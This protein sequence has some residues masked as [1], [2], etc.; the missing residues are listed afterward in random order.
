[1]TEPIPYQTGER[2]E[3]SVTRSEVLN[4]VVSFTHDAGG[5]AAAAYVAGQAIK[6]TGEVITTKI[7]ANVEVVK[8]YFDAGQ[9]NEPAAHEE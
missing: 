2:V 6:T 3:G 8:A 7:N 4:A 5:P 1:M 9:P